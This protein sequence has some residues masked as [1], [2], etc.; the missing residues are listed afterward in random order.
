[1]IPESQFVDQLLLLADMGYAVTICTN[2]EDNGTYTL[3]VT[4]GYDYKAEYTSR[5]IEAM[6]NKVYNTLLFKPD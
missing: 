3:I 6:M 5:C 4:D 1:M 2:Y